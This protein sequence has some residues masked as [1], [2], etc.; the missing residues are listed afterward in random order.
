M[1]SAAMPASSTTSAMRSMTLADLEHELATTRRVL[2]RVPYDRGAWRPH[3]KSW[4]VAQLA[5]HIANVPMWGV[6][7][8]TSDEMDF[9]ATNPQAPVPTDGAALIASFDGN[10]GRLRA[11]L[12]GLSDEMLQ[13]T[14]TAR[15]GDQ[16]LFALPRLA[17]LRGMILNHMIHHRGQLSVY[18]RQLDVPVPAMYGPSADEGSF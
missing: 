13:A 18:L 1:S 12:D 3:P 5:A 15:R 11:T 14:W 9:A 17:L 7:T 16:V 4:T 6:M 8:C 10:V 2:E